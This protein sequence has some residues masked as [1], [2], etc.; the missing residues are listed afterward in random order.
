MLGKDALNVLEKGQS[1]MSIVGFFMVEFCDVM[2][3]HVWFDWIQNGKL[4][5]I[6]SLRH[7]RISLIQAWISALELSAQDPQR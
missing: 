7:G 1:S 4:G 5:V 6:F 3:A 2:I